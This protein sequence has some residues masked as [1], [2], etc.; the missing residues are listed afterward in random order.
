[1]LTLFLGE[2]KGEER[3]KEHVFSRKKATEQS[4]VDTREGGCSQALTVSIA[5]RAVFPFVGAS[6]HHHA[7]YD[8]SS[9]SYLLVIIAIVLTNFLSRN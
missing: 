5:I 4:S 3:Y 1:M 6:S 8:F 7:V 9:S 2:K